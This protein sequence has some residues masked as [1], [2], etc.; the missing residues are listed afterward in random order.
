[1]GKNQPV[2]EKL[3]AKTKADAKKRFDVWPSAYASGWLVK[4]YKRRFAEKHGKRKSPY[5]ES[6]KP[7]R[8]SQKSRG[9]LDR[10]FKEDWRNVCETDRRGRYKKCGRS[11]AGSSSHDYPYC[12]PSRRVSDATP[13]T[14]GEMSE[15]ELKQ[16]CRKKERAQRKKKPGQKS[17]SRVYDSKGAS[18]LRKSKRSRSRGS[19]CESPS[20]TLREC[21]S[22]KIPV[23][24]REGYPQKQAIAIAYSICTYKK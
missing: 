16:M 2:D 14:I 9:D 7:R 17:P 6:G 22:C 11:S 24:M 1:M 20:K 8:R 3:Y 4:E 18:A 15:R 21:V 12:R 19:S 23:L 5:V 10:W 13:K